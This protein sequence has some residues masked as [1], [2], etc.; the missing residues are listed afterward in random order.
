MQSLKEQITISAKFIDHIDK[1]PLS[2]KY[3]VKLYDKDVFDDDYLGQ[4]LL[5][6]QGRAQI[7]FSEDQM[8]S[9]DSPLERHP[10]LYFVLTK[11]DKVIYKSNIIKN[12]HL[13]NTADFTLSAGK[14]YDLG[15]FVV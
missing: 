11:K 13:D 10:D 7:K 14:H 9:L 8:R 6:N 12:L 2:S 3:L 1:M 5:D 15:T 4:S